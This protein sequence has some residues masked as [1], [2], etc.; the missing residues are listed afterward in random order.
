MWD[1]NYIGKNIKQKRKEFK[2]SQVKL[3]EIINVHYHSI[4]RY[5]QGIRQIPLNKLLKLAEYFNVP[6]EYFYKDLKK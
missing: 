1:K 6:I 2:L 5:E 4:Q 3:G